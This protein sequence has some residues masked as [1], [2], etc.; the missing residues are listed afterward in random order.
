MV[1]V[2]L[3]IADRQWRGWKSVAVTRSIEQLAGTFEL[4]LTDRWTHNGEASV[5][6]PGDACRIEAG[7]IPLITGFIDDLDVRVGANDHDI[8]V[9]GRDRTADL[10]DCSVADDPGEWRGAALAEI[11]R[12]ICRPF[13]IEVEA[14]GAA[15]VVIDTFRV[16]Q[17]E[18]AFAAI[19]RA[20]R[21]RGLLAHSDSLGSL[22]ICSLDRERAPRHATA[23]AYGGNVERASAAFSNRN[24]F[25]VYRVKGHGMGGDEGLTSEAHEPLGGAVDTSILRYR[26]LTVLAEDQGG[27]DAFRRRAEWEAAVRAARA[28]RAEV[29][30]SGW[31]D[32]SG[33]HWR[34]GWLV[35]CDIPPLGVAGDMRIAEAVFRF[36][37]QEGSTANLSLAG[38]GS[39]LPEPVIENKEEGDWGW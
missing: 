1:D 20:V 13:V 5:I 17:G 14:D 7:G 36:D 31:T 32:G 21:P 22:V 19:E 26:P 9:R 8:I 37:G 35:A 2:S 11:V 10:V 29:T 16:E 18:T 6:R 23:L 39:F 4:A 12:D 15:D 24:R 34:P 3:I 28:R 27:S 25:S 38:P 30:V 33:A